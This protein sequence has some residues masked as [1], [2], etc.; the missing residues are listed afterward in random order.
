MPW[1][2]TASSPS[3]WA[4]KLPPARRSSRATTTRSATSTSSRRQRMP[5]SRDEFDAG[6]EPATPVLDFHPDNSDRAYT[7]GELAA[8]LSGTDVTID[9]LDYALGM[10]VSRGTI[11]NNT[12]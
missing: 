7:F 11:E 5:L 2:Q 6:G 8:E 1:P 4:K 9:D 3:L 12:L 10:L